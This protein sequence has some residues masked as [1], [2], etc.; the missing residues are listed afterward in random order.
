MLKTDNFSADNNL[1][2]WM[3]KIRKKKGN[4]LKIMKNVSHILF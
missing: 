3:I 4:A 1:H 2:D